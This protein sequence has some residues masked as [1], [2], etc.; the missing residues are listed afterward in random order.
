M[1]TNGLIM[2]YDNYFELA[3]LLITYLTNRTI[4]ISIPLFIGTL[5]CLYFSFLFVSGQRKNK[6]IAEG[7]KGQ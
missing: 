7:I 4:K 6:C 1:H 3:C 2:T 5:L